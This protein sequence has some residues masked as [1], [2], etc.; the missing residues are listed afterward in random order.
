MTYVAVEQLPPAF[1]GYH[2]VFSGY[3]IS[4]GV[5]TPIFRVST[6]NVSKYA[7][8]NIFEAKTLIE[9]LKNDKH[10]TYRIILP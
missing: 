3:S 5:K 9:S 6:L 7:I 10:Y 2:T 8:L 1:N 4:N